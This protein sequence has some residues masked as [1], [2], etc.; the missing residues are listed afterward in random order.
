M[1]KPTLWERVAAL[2]G[3]VA[4]LSP[5]DHSNC[6]HSNYDYDGN[7]AREGKE[8]EAEHQDYEVPCMWCGKYICP[9]CTDCLDKERAKQSKFHASSAIP[10]KVHIID[11]LRTLHSKGTP[12]GW[13]TIREHVRQVIDYIEK[14]C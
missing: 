13:L 8:Q 7:T 10:I 2:E 12:S 5:P 6:D 11:Y 3:H 1:A 9:S 14:E 4:S